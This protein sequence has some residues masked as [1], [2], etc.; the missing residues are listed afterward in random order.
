LYL[1]VYVL[2]RAQLFQ[3]NNKT[4]CHLKRRVDENLTFY[5]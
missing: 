2:Y 4:F 1:D 3:R 5:Y